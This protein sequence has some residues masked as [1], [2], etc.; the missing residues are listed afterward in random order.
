ML[1]P[2]TTLVKLFGWEILLCKMY[3]QAQME[4]SSRQNIVD[5]MGI[6][7]NIKY[8]CM[9]TVYR[10]IYTIVSVHSLASEIREFCVGYLG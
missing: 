4:Y 10:S 7:K 8:I 2:T 9:H 3:A 5:I 6:Y 1:A